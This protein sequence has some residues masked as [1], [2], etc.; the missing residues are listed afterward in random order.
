MNRLFSL[1]AA[2]L[3]ALLSGCATTYTSQVSVF[4]EW[5][6]QLSDKAYAFAPTAAQ[7]KD[8]EYKTY[9][10]QLRHRLQMLGFQE[11]KA[12]AMPALQVGMQYGT[13]LSEIEYSYPWHPAL[14]D[15]FWRMHFSHGYYLRSSFYYP[16]YPYPYYFGRPFGGMWSNMDVTVRRYYLHQLEIG[17]TEVKTGKKLADIKASSEQLSPEISLQMPY[18]IDSALLGFPGKNGG[19]STV[20]L[21]LE[22]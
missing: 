8:P 13:T 22:K 1:C 2:A 11:S 18:L 14:Y 12:G 16:Y 19:T 3:L 7:A 17:I 21:P 10:E 9:E 6:A 4:H 20:E 5:P 15:P